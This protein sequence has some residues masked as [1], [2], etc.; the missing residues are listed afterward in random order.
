MP[1]KEIYTFATKE[2]D[3]RNI[4]YTIILAASHLPTRITTKRKKSFIELRIRNQK[5]KLKQ[6]TLF[7]QS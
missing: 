5:E 4:L 1:F 7:M 3:M 2:S 6:T